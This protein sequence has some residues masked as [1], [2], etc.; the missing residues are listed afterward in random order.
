MRTSVYLD[1]ENNLGQFVAQKAGISHA[2]PGRSGG[3]RQTRSYWIRP[4]ET[5]VEPMA[6]EK[7]SL[8][9]WLGGVAAVYVGGPPSFVPR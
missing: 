4:S 9:F 1:P 7:F 5:L 8:V 6:V 3:K 2:G